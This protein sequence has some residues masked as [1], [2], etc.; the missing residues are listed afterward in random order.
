[1]V[2]LIQGTHTTYP[3]SDAFRPGG[4]IPEL[5]QNRDVRS[6]VEASVPQETPILT[7]VGFGEALNMSRKPEWGV[8][9][10]L[11]RQTTLSAP[12]A[13]SVAAKDMKVAPGDGAIF[14]KYN[15]C[16][17]FKKDA[18]GLPDYNRREQ[19]WV[20]GLP[21]YLDAGTQE[22]DN[23][24]ISRAQGGTTALAFAAGDIVQVMSVAYPEGQDFT[25]SPDTYGK[26]YYN[27]FQAIERGARITK[28]A[29]GLRNYE[30]RD[31]NHIAR[32]MQLRSRWVRRDLEQAI[33][34]GGRQLG[35]PNSKT[36]STMAGLTT[37]VQAGNTVNLNGH[38]ISPYDLEAEGARLWETFNEGERGATKRLL[39]SQHTARLMDGLLNRYRVATM[40][41]TSID[42]RFQR[43]VT[44]FGTFEIVGTRWIPEGIVLGVDFANL[45]VHP[46]VG[47]AWQEF[48]HPV[49]GAYIQ[50]TIWGEYTL[51]CLRPETMFMIYGFDT[52][53]GH[54]GRRI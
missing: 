9:E 8:G 36:P 48:D 51:I 53:P 10:D 14:Q 13:A 39:M 28:Q 38:R 21:N 45:K 4:T 49:Q 17:L 46:F 16:L 5:H 18:Y 26:W 2:I 19:V 3:A 42:L 43:F 47:C 23:I 6:F 32:L 22:V 12:L 20:H 30:F 37:F 33:V 50:R 7:A 44:R 1:M 35:D 25:I 52:N 29:N 34:S 40:N 54:Y 27:Y 41:D 24:P 31:G 11:P 15:L